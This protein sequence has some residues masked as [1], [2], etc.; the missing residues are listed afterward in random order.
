MGSGSVERRSKRH[1]L[2]YKLSSEARRIR[3]SGAEFQGRS[4][5]RVRKATAESRDK[6]RFAEQV[7]AVVK[8]FLQPV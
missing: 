3:K 7:Q 1:S 8:T 6:R 4:K 5:I 2:W